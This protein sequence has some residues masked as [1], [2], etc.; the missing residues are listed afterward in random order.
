MTTPTTTTSTPFRLS[1]EQYIILQ[2]VGI[3]CL[4]IMVMVM[5][6]VMAMVMVMVM[7]MAMAMAMVM[8][9]VMVC[10]IFRMVEWVHGANMYTSSGGMGDG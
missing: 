10:V 5:V 9:T 2:A 6:M 3:P 4:L 1:E 8:V 7:V